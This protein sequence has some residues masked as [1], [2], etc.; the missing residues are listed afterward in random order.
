MSDNELRPA[1]GIIS[2]SFKSIGRHDLPGT[3]A[4]S[5]PHKDVMFRFSNLRRDSLS[6]ISRNVHRDRSLFH[7]SP[8]YGTYILGYFVIST[9]ELMS[10]VGKGLY[11]CLSR[12]SCVVWNF[13]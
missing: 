13:G 12:S 6:M 5:E 9:P 4:S 8:D 11:W 1:A 3:Y 7:L 10:E 2:F